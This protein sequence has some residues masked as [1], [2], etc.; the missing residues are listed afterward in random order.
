MVVVERGHGME[1]LKRRLGIWPEEIKTPD[2]RVLGKVGSCGA[3]EREHNARLRRLGWERAEADTQERNYRRG[4]LDGWVAAIDSLYGLIEERSPGKRVPAG[5][6]EAYREA[7]DYW[8][9][10]PLWHWSRESVP[11]DAPLPRVEPPSP[12]Q[13]WSV[14][15]P[16]DGDDEEE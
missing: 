2:G 5:I 13:R 16:D 12:P 9:T 15:E 11:A 14:P 10:G 3:H 4:Y 6:R 1:W 8:H 7:W